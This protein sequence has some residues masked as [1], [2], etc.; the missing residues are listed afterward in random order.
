MRNNGDRERRM[1]VLAISP[2]LDDAALS[3]GATLADFAAQGADVEV[4]TLFAGTP[5]EPL[6]PVARAFHVKCHLP[7]DTSAVALRIKEDRAA[8]NELGARARHR[9]FLDAV[10]RRGPDGQWLCHHDRAM[11]DDQPIDQDDL[12][13]EISHQV[14]Y[15]ITIR[16]PD[17][18]LSCAAVG[19]HIDHRLT[20]AAALNTATGASVPILLWEDLPYAI[21]RPPTAA[22]ALR[23]T[24]PPAAW[25]RKWRAIAC[26]TSQ[27]RM[28]WPA[29]I[30]WIT[31]LLA[32]AKTRGGRYGGPPAELL[33]PSPRRPVDFWH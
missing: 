2:H 31:Q 27:I 28:L 23:F 15:L 26:Y 17:L 3:A 5:R 10:Y 18:V 6:S 33:S 32:H 12:L 11:F 16:K 25:E 19:D 9:E 21:G 30:D 13:D 22:P 8:M 7:E 4:V 24:A 29:E 1:R 14:R 20:R